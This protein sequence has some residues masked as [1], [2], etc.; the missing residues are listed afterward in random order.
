MRP[1]TIPAVLLALCLAGALTAEDPVMPDTVSSPRV[2][3]E[4]RPDFHSLES[5]LADPRFAGKQGEAL[6]L[7]IYDYFT[8]TLDGTWHWWTPSERAGDPYGWGT[9]TDPVKLLNAYGWMLCGT[10]ANVLQGLYQAAGMPSRIRGLPGHVV[11]EVFYERR[12]HILD[13]DMWTW[14]RT[15]EGHLASIEELSAAPRPLIVDN[16]RK[17]QP[18]NLP[19][20]TLPDYAAMYEQAAKQEKCIFPFW[21]ARLHTMDFVLRPGEMLLRSQGHAG[22]FHMPAE[23]AAS[24]AKFANEWQGLP[25]E[26]YEPFRT[27]G[28][29][30]WS[31]TPDLTART[32]DVE[33]GAW[34]REGLTQYERGLAGPGS[35]VFRIQTPY[36]FCGVPDAA[37]EGFPACDGF[38]LDLA[39]TGAVRAEI[40]DAEGR[41]VEVAAGEGPRSADL[42]ALLATR[43]DAMLRLTLAAGARLDRLACEG[44]LQVA[45]MSLPRLAAGANRMQ[46]R[47]GDQ[48]GRRTTPWRVPADFRSEAA[49][50]TT[51]V[52][53]EHGK[54]VPGARER[55]QLAPPADGPAVAVF[56]FDAPAGRPFAW[57]YAVATLPE[58]P[59]DAAPKQAVLEW[60]E[61]GAAWRPL[62]TIAIANTPLQWD[63][64]LDG[65][66]RLP[67]PAPRLWLRV[68]SAT[69]L[70][71][72][73]FA[74][75][76]A[77][78][79]SPAGLRIVHR[80]REDAGE[81]EFA[82]PAGADAWSVDCGAGPREHSIEMRAPSVPR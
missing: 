2:V 82:V 58:G 54:L 19:D 49:L 81:R 23:W 72:L 25:R 57:A 14:F 51:L 61:D 43:Y 34:T 24:K 80:W 28:N 46:L 69:G 17:S 4:F 33:F 1:H 71:A 52:G 70:I 64:S 22:R 77:E 40:T 44:W 75:H 32:R 53:V 7:A 50:R 59:A 5:I 73:E 66:V 31:Y 18:C 11:C 39:S 9:V 47:C 21:A 74:G 30:R 60:S 63:C 16:Q 29:G 3:G 35:L 38:R 36:P 45:P 6:A 55:L 56:R 78:P 20:R 67:A 41:W 68:I 15:P 62:S 79:A 27:I 42:T 76:A 10:N 26:R 37:K 12:W 48:Y 65:T 13:V 8:S